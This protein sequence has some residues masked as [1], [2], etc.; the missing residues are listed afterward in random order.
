MKTKN[1][2]ALGVLA[3]ASLATGCSDFEDLNHDPNKAEDTQ[4]QPQWFLN[5]SIIGAQMNPEIAER[6]FVLMLFSK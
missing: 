4:V 1:I 5:N 2:L 3:L 6:I